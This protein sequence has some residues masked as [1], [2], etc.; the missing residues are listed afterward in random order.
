MTDSLIAG[1]N[2]STP[3]ELLKGVDTLPT[4]EINILDETDFKR[5]VYTGISIV[6]DTP[7]VKNSRN[8]LFG[9]NIDGFIPNYNYRENAWQQ[10]YKN[11]FPVQPFLN[12]HTFVRTFQEQISLPQQFLY[13]SHRFISGNVGIG[14]RIS[15]NTAQT[16][17][18]LITQAS[19]M[20]RRYYSNSEAWAGLS[21]QNGSE[22]TSDYA[23]G[24]FVLGDI[25][26]NR[27]ISI[28]PI[29][30][31]PLVKTDLARKLSLINVWP[32]MS[33]QAAFNTFNIHANQFAEDWLLVG[34]LSSLPNSAASQIT[35][36]FFFDYSQVQFYTPLLPIIRFPPG[37]FGRQILHV[38]Q[39]FINGGI[40]KNTAAWSP[41]GPGLILSE[42]ENKKSKNIL[43]LE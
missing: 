9:I 6:I 17:N 15:S 40:T 23:V 34:I 20:V 21:F 18:L 24:N 14:M 5:F 16:G 7:L 8:A 36:S 1:I 19:S 31:D 38:S 10:I 33:T 37:N 43:D 25:S 32:T 26:L 11:L 3:T 22:S 4:P 13:A 12:S 2:L 35:I 39:S 41:G 30:K 42:K 28:T 27:N 29:R